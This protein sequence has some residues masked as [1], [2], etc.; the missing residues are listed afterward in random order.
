MYKGEKERL[1]L[2]FALS[3]LLMLK[4]KTCL[5]RETLDRYFYQQ[6]S[7]DM[8][9]KLFIEKLSS[10]QEET[11][12][13]ITMGGIILGLSF[14]RRNETFMSEIFLQLSLTNNKQ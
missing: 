3:C 6:Y 9:A 1:H 13:E 5:H 10:M 14:F 4:C 2:F 7:T 12:A 8:K 11:A